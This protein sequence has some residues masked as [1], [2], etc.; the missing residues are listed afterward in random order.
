MTLAWL[1][2]RAVATISE[3]GSLCTT[4][5]HILALKEQRSAVCLQLNAALWLNA[6]IQDHFTA[7]NVP[8]R[9]LS[10]T[11]K[12]IPDKSSL[13]GVKCEAELVK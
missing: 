4:C 13:I 9:S 10:V 12:N 1:Q 5:I 11:A 7:V 2:Q 8:K 3:A 6:A